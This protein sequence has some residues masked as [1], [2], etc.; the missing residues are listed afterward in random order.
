L[1]RL[2]RLVLIAE[3]WRASAVIAAEARTNQAAKRALAAAALV[4]VVLLQSLLRLLLVRADMCGQ[5][6]RRGGACR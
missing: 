5:L 6:L 1:L 3:L 4:A 2:L